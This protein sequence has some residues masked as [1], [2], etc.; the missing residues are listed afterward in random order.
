MGDS[1]G[2]AS[3]G[4]CHAR[5]SRVRCADRFELGPHSGPYILGSSEKFVAGTASPLSPR[6]TVACS[7]NEV[8]GRGLG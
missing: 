4:K 7:G 5:L 2:G 8:A 6:G 1:C 3:N